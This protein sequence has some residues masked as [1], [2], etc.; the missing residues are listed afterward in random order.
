MKAGNDVLHRGSTSNGRTRRVRVRCLGI[1]R[2]LRVLI[3]GSASG[4][5]AAQE[6]R[7]GRTRFALPSGTETLQP[8]CIPVQLHSLHLRSA[9]VMEKHLETYPDVGLSEACFALELTD[10]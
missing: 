5:S 8:V 3:S 7:G 10:E 1:V 2:K 4:F 6:D 9:S